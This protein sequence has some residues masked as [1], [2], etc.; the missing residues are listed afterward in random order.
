MGEDS[1]VCQAFI[2]NPAIV[3]IAMPSENSSGAT[4]G[5]LWENRIRGTTRDLCSGRSGFTMELVAAAAR[6]NAS[7]WSTPC[8]SLAGGALKSIEP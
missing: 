5:S 1:P 7:C 2:I 8:P 3:A 6:R 4:Q